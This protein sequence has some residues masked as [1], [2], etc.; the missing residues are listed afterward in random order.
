MNTI[1]NLIPS[2]K[3]KSK[4]IFSTN[5]KAPKSKIPQIGDKKQSKNLEKFDRESILKIK[6]N[7][8]RPIQ[9]KFITKLMVKGKKEQ[10]EQILLKALK[11]V[12][13]EL[14]KNKLIKYENISGSVVSRGV[15]SE[16]INKS[17]LNKIN[18]QD[19][20]A[21]KNTEGNI[22]VEGVKQNKKK[23]PFELK[24][25][26]NVRD[27]VISR[28]QEGNASVEKNLSLYK[29]LDKIIQN[30]KPLVRLKKVRIAGTT[31]QKPVGLTKKQAETDA[32]KRIITNA[33]GRSEKSIVLKLAKEFEEIYCNILSNKTLTEVR[34]LH[35]LAEINKANVTLKS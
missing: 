9:Q 18:K 28:I 15:I 23:T 24:N 21:K 25:Q 10:G 33:N 13:Q 11:K 26:K 2:E 20:K 7:E 3:L 27:S 16:E 22:K 31:H 5:S 32:I 17:N 12:E 1:E 6:L 35:K 8:E 14:L 19:S 34:D 30:A 29:I 4:K